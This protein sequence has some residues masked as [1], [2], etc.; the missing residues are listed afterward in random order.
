MTQLWRCDFKDCKNEVKYNNFDEG[1]KVRRDESAFGVGVSSY[2]LCH[3]HAQVLERFM[4]K[5]GE[6]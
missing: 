1:L 6:K 2:F 5:E 4:R 3:E